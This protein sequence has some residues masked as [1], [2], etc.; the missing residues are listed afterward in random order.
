MSLL[1]NLSL[2]IVLAAV[3]PVIAAAQA[4]IYGKLDLT[5]YTSNGDVKTFLGG[6][7]GLYD[8]FIHAGPLHAGLDLRGSY[9]TATDLEYRD[10]LIGIRVGLTVPVVRLRPYVQGSVGVGGTKVKAQTAPGIVLEWNNRLVEAGFVGMD[11]TVLPHIDWR[12]AEIGFARINGLSAS[13]FKAS[14]GAVL[15]F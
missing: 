6:G 15:R 14:T 11:V 5:N 8:D 10:F 1:R 12:V 9:G 4:G 3:A 7:G 13:E 2:G